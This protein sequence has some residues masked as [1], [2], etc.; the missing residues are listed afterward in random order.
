ML[1]AFREFVMRG[2]V[3][4]LAVAVI[5]GAAFGKIVTSLVNDVIMPPIGMLLGRI[6][7]ANLFINLSDKPYATL[8]AA[9]A[10]GAPAIGFGVFLNTVIYFLIIA[11]VLF[12]IIR[13]F[14]RAKEKSEEDE[15]THEMTEH[16]HHAME[17]REKAGEASAESVSPAAESSTTP[18]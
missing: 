13:P 6:D 3:V 4:D 18:E 2:N 5:I 17:E 8:D 14:N 1:K 9:R 11:L 15:K 16:V 7:F 10:A 12:F